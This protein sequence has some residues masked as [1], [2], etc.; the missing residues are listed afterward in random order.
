MSPL[1][2]L[3]GRPWL[4]LSLPEQTHCRNLENTAKLEEKI[5]IMYDFTWSS[6][7]VCFLPIRSMH[8]SHIFFFNE[9]ALYANN[10]QNIYYIIL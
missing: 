5:K 9:L 8:V 10:F 6:F 2:G 3:T 4:P 7:L 1:T